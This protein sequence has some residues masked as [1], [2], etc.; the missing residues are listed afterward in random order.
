MIDLSTKYMGFDLK[1][2]I[3]PSASPLSRDVDAVRQMEDYGAAAIVMDSL[4]EEEIKFEAEELN[5]FLELGTESYAESTTYYPKHDVYLVGPEIYLERIKKLKEAVDIPVIA[6]LNGTDAGEWTKYAKMIQEAGADAIE[7]NIYFLETSFDVSSNDIDTLYLDVLKAVKTNVDIPVAMKLSPFFSSFASNAK[8]FCD[9][10]NADALVLFNRFMQPGFDIENL[11]VTQHVELSTSDEMM[12]PLR[13]IAILYGQVS[14]SLAH[15]RGI[16]THED[17]I[18]AI[19]AGAD[20][21]QITSV[22]LKNGVKQI[23]K[24]LDDLVRWMEEHEYESLE[25]MKGS[26]SMKSSPDP[27]AF[28]RANYMKML[29][30]YKTV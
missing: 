12:L 20:I 6:S 22:L 15:T 23:K 28:A 13:W 9:E 11:E 18:K 3:V 5:H 29:K 17:I 21:T 25:L 10:G 2:P 16:H 26:L 1:N 8:R 7:L 24:L 14:A 27:S 4:F 30:S 19:M